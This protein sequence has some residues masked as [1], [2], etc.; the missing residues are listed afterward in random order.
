MSYKRFWM[1]KAVLYEP[2]KD[3][4]LVEQAEAG[5]LRFNLASHSSIPRD[6][7]HHLILTTRGRADEE[8]LY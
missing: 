4:S 8:H 2:S 3:R 6:V 5:Y 7:G 1:L